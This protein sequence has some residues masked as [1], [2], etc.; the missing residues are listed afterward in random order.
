MPVAFILRRSPEDSGLLPDFY[1]A[2]ASDS[3][4]QSSS[5]ATVS[6]TSRKAL[7][8]SGFRL[9]LS[10]C[11][12]NQAALSSVLAHAIPFATDASFSASARLAVVV[13]LI[14]A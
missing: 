8:K 5:A 2:H 3:G 6:L 14:I 12:M 10:G 7:R 1:A 9:L 11:S 13:A 4:P